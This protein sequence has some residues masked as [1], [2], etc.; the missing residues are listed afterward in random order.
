MPKYGNVGFRKL[1]TK[2]IDMLPFFVIVGVIIGY[3]VVYVYTVGKTLDDIL[4][5]E[6]DDE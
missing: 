6:V 5:P 4:D 1:E 3:I 2:E